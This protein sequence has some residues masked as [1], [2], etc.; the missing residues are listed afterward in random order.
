MSLPRR[1]VARKNLAPV[2]LLFSPDS[3]A[4]K[5]KI[6]HCAENAATSVALS[7]KHQRVGCGLLSV[8]ETHH[9][10]TCHFQHIALWGTC[11]KT[12]VVPY[13]R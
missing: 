1:P 3:L 8:R 7:R 11:G 10:N 13:S 2:N 5:I 6:G 4:E 9:S 12:P